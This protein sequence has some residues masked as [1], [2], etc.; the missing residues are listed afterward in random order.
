MSLVLG[1]D[2]GW[3][4]LASLHLA[5]PRTPRQYFGEPRLEPIDKTHQPNK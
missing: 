4:L 5:A 2:S 1:A 3:Q